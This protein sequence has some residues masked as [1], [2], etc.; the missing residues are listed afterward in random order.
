MAD[1]QL[2]PS[3]TFE[4]RK[5]PG[6]FL[7][8]FTG[9]FSESD[10]LMS[11]TSILRNPF[12]WLETNTPPTTPDSNSDPKR[13]CWEKLES[14]GVGLGIIDSLEKPNPKPSSP[15][16]STTPRMVLKIQIPSLNSLPIES[17]KSPIEFGVETKTSQ[18]GVAGF[19]LSSEDYTCVI[20]RGPVPRTTHIFDNCVVNV[21]F[22]PG[23]R[24]SGDLGDGHRDGI[25]VSFPSSSFLS[26]CCTCMKRLG[27]GSD[28]YMYSGEKAF[29]SD[30]CRSKEMTLEES[31]HRKT[32]C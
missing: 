13:H 17:P 11:P 25:S 31:K 22:S 5:K 4:K 23:R 3:P 24:E 7:F 8:G 27:E 10:T 15:D 18:V 9:F 2:L 32:W 6:S 12:C 19:S 30:E 21:G 29:C 1:H 14:K 26:F 20:A 28:I 16:G